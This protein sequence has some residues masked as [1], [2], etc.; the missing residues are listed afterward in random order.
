MIPAPVLPANEDELLDIA[1]LAQRWKIPSQQVK[2]RICENRMPIPIVRLGPRSPRFRLSD[3]AAFES[4]VARE[5]AREHH[6]ERASSEASTRT[7][8]PREQRV[9]PGRGAALANTTKRQRGAQR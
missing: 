2:R 4:R 5:G 1:A 9:R 6:E 3:V 8:A 7:L